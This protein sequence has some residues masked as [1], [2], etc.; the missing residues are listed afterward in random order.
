MIL[1]IAQMEK[2]LRQKDLCGTGRAGGPSLWLGRQPP[3]PLN[4]RFA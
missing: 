2:T 1:A 3:A 4:D